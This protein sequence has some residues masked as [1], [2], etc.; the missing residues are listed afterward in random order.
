MVRAISLQGQL[1]GIDS[2][3]QVSFGRE[4]KTTG[5]SM[6]NIRCSIYSMARTLVYSLKASMFI[7][8]SESKGID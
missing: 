1:A 2:G 7:Q 8:F 3:V 4:V 5:N 6:L